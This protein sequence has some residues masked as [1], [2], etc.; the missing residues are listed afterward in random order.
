M[1]PVM[2]ANLFAA[3]HKQLLRLKCFWQAEKLQF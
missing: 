1:G 3:M 2:W